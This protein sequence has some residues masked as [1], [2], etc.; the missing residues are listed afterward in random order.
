MTLLVNTSL[1]LPPSPTVVTIGSEILVSISLKKGFF[2]HS[3]SFP[4]KIAFFSFLHSFSVHFCAHEKASSFPYRILRE[5]RLGEAVLL[6][7]FS[8][9]LTQRLIPLLLLP[10]LPPLVSPHFRF[11]AGGWGQWGGMRGDLP[12]PFS[13]PGMLPGSTSSIQT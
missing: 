11:G 5:P 10:A 4:F 8:V 2:L 6:V 13:V 12:H 1:I 7:C 9:R 3:K